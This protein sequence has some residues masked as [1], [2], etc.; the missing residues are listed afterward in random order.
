MCG[1]GPEQDVHAQSAGARGGGGGGGGAALRP[2]PPYNVQHGPI[3]GTQY[4]ALRAGLGLRIHPSGDAG[5][6]GRPAA[7]ESLH[8]PSPSVPGRTAADLG[9]DPASTPSDAVEPR[10][11][12]ARRARGTA[13]R[14]GARV[15]RGAGSA[16]QM[17]AWQGA[18]RSPPPPP[19][20]ISMSS[21]VPGGYD[22]DG[23]QMLEP[24]AGPGEALLLA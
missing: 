1:G 24:A 2:L 5:P 11:G 6:L 12:L 22:P 8:G 14:A 19:H 10:A 13:G 3:R 18:A 16:G 23:G 4:S 21:S 17:S 7:S 15:S 20:V 9:S